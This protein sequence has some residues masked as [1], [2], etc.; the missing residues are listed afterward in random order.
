MCMHVLAHMGAGFTKAYR[1]KQRRAQNSLHSAP[2]PDKHTF[3]AQHCSSCSLLDPAD[4]LHLEGLGMS[5]PLPEMLVVTRVVIT[6]QHILKTSV[7]RKLGANPAGEGK[8]QTVTLQRHQHGDWAKKPTLQTHSSLPSVSGMCLSLSTTV[9][10]IML[11]P[12]PGTP[13][14]PFFVWPSCI[15]PLGLSSII[16]PS[17]WS[18]LFF[19]LGHSP[20]LYLWNTHVIR[21]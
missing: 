2:V 6:L 3:T 4:T 19:N 16:T 8:R 11:F 5:A 18:E 13:F 7:A 15:Y 12:L 17:G 9:P 1:G 10:F 14:Q 21:N 20:L